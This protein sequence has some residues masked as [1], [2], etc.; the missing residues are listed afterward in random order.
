M[1]GGLKGGSYCHRSVLA[2]LTGTTPALSR[3]LLSVLSIAATC[4]CRASSSDATVMLR[5]SCSDAE[6][7]SQVP[8]LSPKGCAGTPH[9]HFYGRTLPF[10]LGLS[11]MYI[12][13]TH[14]A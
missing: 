8:W 10:N 12:Q 11:D 5:L 4:M 3:V 14:K 1:Y 6:F 7:S 13:A 2:P 9:A